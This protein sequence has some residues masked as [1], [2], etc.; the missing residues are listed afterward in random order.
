MTPPG[1]DIAQAQSALRAAKTTLAEMQNLRRQ[2]DALPDA[3][4]NANPVEVENLRGTLEGMEEKQ[5]IFIEQLGGALFPTGT[6]ATDSINPAGDDGSANSSAIKESTESLRLL[7]EEM[8]VM[9][10]QFDALSNKQ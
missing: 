10:A 6:D 2:I 3:V 8:K 9:K 5:T 1:N 4:K 7:A